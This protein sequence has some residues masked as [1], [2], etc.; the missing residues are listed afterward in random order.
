MSVKFF[1]QFLIQQGEVDAGHVREALD[2]LGKTNRTLGELAVEAGMMTEVDVRR[3]NQGQ[4]GNDKPFGDLAVELGML[5]PAQL[6]ECLRLQSDRRLKIGEALVHLGHLPTERL[7]EL[8]DAFKAD[9]ADYEVGALG[10]LPDQ[11]A[12]NRVAPYV[13]DLLPKFCMRIARIS[14]KLGDAQVLEEAPHWAYRVSLPIHA[15][16]GLDVTLV[17]DRAFCARLASGTSGVAESKLDHELLVDGVGEFLN[18]LAGNAISALERSGVQAELGIPDH[19][20]ELADG[21]LFD[22]AT[23][24]GRSAL[25]LMQF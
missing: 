25:V 13:L 1:G 23:S 5:E 12:N 17:G 11:L 8:L 4:R 14:L 3:V 9:Q 20:A 15:H 22:L 16:R 10:Q 19:D 21:W 2:L 24:V 6:V 18:V 7:G